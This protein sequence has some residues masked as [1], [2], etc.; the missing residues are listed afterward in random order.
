MEKNNSFDE[1]NNFLKDTYSQNKLKLKKR[2][3][4]VII[5]INIIT[6]SCLIGAGIGIKSIIDYKKE[7]QEN[8]NIQNKL[9]S[10][11]PI[12]MKQ[13]DKN[14]EEEVEEDK[15]DFSKLLSINSD[16][17]GW[18]KV[19][20]TGVDLPIVQTD[21]NTYYLNHNFEKK[22]NSLGWAFA[23]YRNNFNNLSKN[24]ILY[25]HTYKD[26]IIFSTLKNAL[27]NNWQENKDNLIIEFSTVGNKM[28]WQIFSIYTLKKTN[29][30]LKV[31]FTDQE[32]Y[33]YIDLI[34][35]RSIK[36]Y[37]VDINL[38]DNILTLSTCYNDSNHRLVIHAKLIKD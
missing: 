5:I 34:K 6:I 19:N 4:I 18:L 3:K 9:L 28:D 30:Y 26:T 11:H 15:Y 32:F 10:Y 33:N 2:K 31:D 36:D 37:N 12:L 21:N 8:A 25:G 17:V 16:T 23:D 14:E 22:W 29:D 35:S 27:K 24:T 7:Y 38:E 1:L 13:D 20:N